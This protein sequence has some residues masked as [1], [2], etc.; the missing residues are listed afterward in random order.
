MT[1]SKV[2]LVYPN[3]MLV[4]LLPNN[5]ALLSGSLKKAGYN[6][7]LFDAT[8]YKT[9]VKTNDEMRVERMQVRKFNINEAGIKI[10]DGDICSDFRHIVKEYKPDLIAVSVVDDTVRMG[11]DLIKSLGPNKIPVVFGGVHAI[12]NPESLISTYLTFGLRMKKGK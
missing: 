3:L 7:R 6:V 1:K 5:V 2:L 11:L 4:S 9:T 8:L 12:L 10:K